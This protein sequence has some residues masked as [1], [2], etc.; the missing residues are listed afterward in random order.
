MHFT[1]FENVEGQVAVY[2]TLK[3]FVRKVFASR[4]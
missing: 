1:D 3:T 4:A 2:Q